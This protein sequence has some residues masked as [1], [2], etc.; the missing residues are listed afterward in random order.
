MTTEEKVDYLEVDKP[1]PGQNYTC[2]SFVS[3]DKILKQKELFLFN[4][5]MN[6]R[7]GEYEQSI[8]KI[9]E[10]STDELKDKIGKE[11]KEIL[12][13][14]LKFSY[15]EFKSKFDDFK[16]KFCDELEKSFKE[17][18]GNQTSVRG[19]K[20]RGV[21]DSY[22]EAERRAKELQRTDHSFHVFVGQVGFWL[23]WD[24]EADRVQ[25]EEYLEDE[26]NTLMKGYKENEVNK[27]IFYEEQ[28]RD[29][30]KD[31]MKKRLEQE[32]LNKETAEK[33]EE[34]D[35]WMQ[36]KFGSTE[37]TSSPTTETPASTTTETPSTASSTETTSSSVSTTTG[38][39]D[40]ND[41]TVPKEKLIKEI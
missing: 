1:I 26:L 38:T 12:V 31:A 8:D 29:K 24:P 36:S 11:L 19:V 35:P 2:I 28:K 6:Q 25:K 10:D 30:N 22:G 3:P 21:Y 17:I 15:E 4:K 27:D 14:E 32:K 23:P 33:L 37:T 39:S 5:Y 7:C 13:K 40:S 16:Y 20:V 41:T 9:M 18:A 34:P